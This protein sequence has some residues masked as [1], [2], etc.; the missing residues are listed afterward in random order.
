MNKYIQ[1]HL[2]GVAIG[3]EMFSHDKTNSSKIFEKRVKK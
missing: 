2:K 1:Q 3:F